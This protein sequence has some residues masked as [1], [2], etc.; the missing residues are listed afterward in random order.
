MSFRLLKL[1]VFSFLLLF[2]SLTVQAQEDDDDWF[3][4]D[5]SNHNFNF[6]F[7][8][9]G[10]PTIETNYGFSKN[11]LDRLT[12]KFSKTNLAEIRLGYTREHPIS[13]TE[14]IMKYKSSYVGLSNIS[15]K[16]AQESI[17]PDYNADM[18]RFS[19]GWDNGY[20]YKLGQK[21]AIIFYNGNGVTWSNLKIKN[22]IPNPADS[23][24]L[25]M[26]NNSFRFGQKTEGG[27]KIQI[28]PQLVL[29]AG[30]ERAQIFPRLLF[31]KWAGSAII[32]VA[33]QAM[34]DEFIDKIV[35]ST[36]MA[37]PV[38]S[39]LLKNGLSYGIYELRKEKMNWPF[40][41]AAPFLTDS[42]KFG[43]TFIF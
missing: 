15:Y 13:S 30:Y 11:S 17:A 43:I 10:N 8:L 39:F 7:H 3:G 9:R 25:G 23:L 24:Y 28:I 5:N 32:E 38:I 40:N 14:S 34:L 4:D 26:F 22:S 16:L 35:D 12:G 33:G 31:W 41:T 20:G 1:S 27:V 29:N 37:A 42:Y 2:V 36:P 6:D 21:S 18:W 19:A